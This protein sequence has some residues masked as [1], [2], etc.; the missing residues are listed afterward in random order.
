MGSIM[1]TDGSSPQ[2]G[3]NLLVN[4]MSNGQINSEHSSTNG[5][6]HTNGFHGESQVPEPIAI[7][8]MAMRLPGGIQDSEALWDF[9]INKKSA[10]CRVPESRYN[11][12]AFYGPGKAGHVGTEY[13]YFIEDLDLANLDLSFWSMTKQEAEAVD[14][15]QRLMLEVV[16]ECLE[17]S[18][19]KNWRGQNIGCY[20]GSFGEDW[21][22]ME[23]KD[24]QNS[25]MYRMAG[26]SDFATANRV[27]YEFDFKGPRYVLQSSHKASWANSC[28]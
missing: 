18:G 4:G 2:V 9:L 3:M 28:T 5:S 7:I 1:N 19:A 15:S 10:R 21:L 17:N 11:V 16:Y 22:D 26:Y 12:N 8:G 13:G 20:I 27:S 6:G 23:L 25:N 24:D 14:P